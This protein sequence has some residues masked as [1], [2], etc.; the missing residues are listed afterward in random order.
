MDGELMER[1]GT[2]PVAQQEMNPMAMIAAAVS[3]GADV[4]KLSKLMDLQERYERNEARKAFDTA[5][6]QFKAEAVVIVKS[7][8]VTDG[9]LKG[10]KYAELHSVVSAV[11]PALSRHGLTASW[12]LTKDEKD[13]IEVTCTIRHVRGHFEAVSMGGP[14]DAGGAKNAI[15]ARAS[16]VNYLERY[17]L[18]AACGLAE[19]GEDDDG[20]QARRGLA[21]NVVGDYEAAIEALYEMSAAE[22]LW[23]AIA[24]ACSDAGD[25]ANYDTLKTLMAKK[26]KTLSA[27]PT[28]V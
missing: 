16:T 10:K 21:D 7:K 6:A 5:F 26:R 13:W 19:Q 1:P 12:R 11:T 22:K 4:E 17:T 23:Q 24:K 8:G 15:Q 18:K 3:Q 9:P 28:T 2:L 14:P 25:V 27:K 20:R